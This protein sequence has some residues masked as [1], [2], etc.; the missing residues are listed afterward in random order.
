MSDLR[1]AIQ[2]DMH[3]SG[4][5]ATTFEDLSR[6]RS[7]RRR[8][9][10]VFAG[11]VGAAVFLIVVAWIGSSVLRADG[12][13][14]PADPA[15]VSTEPLAGN[16]P[17][18]W[19]ANDEILMKGTDPASPIVL[20]SGLT[21]PGWEIGSFDW[22]PDGR[23]LAITIVEPLP[24]SIVPCRLLVLEVRD[25]SVN[26]LA[27]CEHPGFGSQTADWSPDGRWIVYAGPGG[28]HVIGADGSHARQLNDDGGFDP[29]WSVDGMIVYAS[30]DRRT[31]LSVAPDGS[32][33]KVV[34]STG[35]GT[36]AVFSPAWSPDGTRIA[37]LQMED[38]PGDPAGSA[39]GT[40][41]WIAAADGSHGVKAAT[42]G[43]CLFASEGF[44]WSPDGSKL[45][46]SGTEIIV[47]HAD[48]LETTTFRRGGALGL[49][50]LD[51]S[52][53]PS[54]RPVA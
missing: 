32:G 48:T 38:L 21:P 23:R 9:Q 53:R 54:W 28:L 22:S 37:Y 8:T 51:M 1:T 41:L 19:V 40:G 30:A 27:D 5:P 49:A 10:R 16:G 35:S 36:Y 50:Q 31:I 7:R 47:I 34:T 15:V 26:D 17:R 3:G 20:G 24:Q 4:L 33:S 46:W 2:R 42:M 12:S 18:T 25:G 39:L 13:T 6:R 52:V 45:I 11:V 44:G 29:S 43:C 14:A